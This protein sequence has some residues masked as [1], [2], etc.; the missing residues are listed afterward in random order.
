MILKMFAIHDSK[1]EAFLRPFFMNTTGLAIRAMEE[2][3]QGGQE[4]WC[5]FPTDFTLFEIGFFDDSL[6]ET[7]MLSTKINLGLLSSFKGDE[8][9]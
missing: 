2:S 6:G 7:D 4:P 5:K 8:Q 9:Q 3:M 1:A